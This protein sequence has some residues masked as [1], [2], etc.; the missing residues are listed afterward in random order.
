MSNK[1]TFQKLWEIQCF[2]VDCNFW[3]I[4]YNSKL[5]WGRFCPN[6]SQFIGHCE[7]VSGYGTLAEQQQ[8]QQQVTFMQKLRAE[9]RIR[10][11][12]Y[13]QRKRLEAANGLWRQF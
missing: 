9:R 12:E 11:L 13:Q 5:S 8:Q 10:L 7:C 2:K 1:Y 6:Y 4:Q 3:C